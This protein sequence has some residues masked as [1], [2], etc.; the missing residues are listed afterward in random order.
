[1]LQ[2]L[3]KLVILISFIALSACASNDTNPIPEPLSHAATTQKIYQSDIP[4]NS[5]ISAKEAY[6]K[7]IDYSTGENNTTPDLIAAV[8][9]IKF[10][11]SKGYAEA[12]FKLG[13]MYLQGIGVPISKKN[14]FLSM[15]IA[16]Q[17]GQA[18]AQ[19]YLSYFYLKGIGTEENF[20]LADYWLNEAKANGAVIE[21]LDLKVP[22]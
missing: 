1:M 7:S 9:W 19:Y 10:S 21:T 6:Q 5:T 2:A 11:A 17:S 16:A 15:L 12:Q 18:Q 4:K 22:K 3:I 20:I 8:N 13:L 14:A